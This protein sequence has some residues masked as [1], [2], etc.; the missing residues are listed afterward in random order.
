MRILAIE[1]GSRRA[2]CALLDEPFDQARIVRT[3]GHDNPKE[4]AERLLSMID[5]LLEA[6]GVLRSTLDVIACGLGPGSFTGIRVALATA[7]G[8]AFALGRPLIGVDSLQA[9][10]R[11]VPA[12]ILDATDIVLPTIDAKKG[13]LF[14]AAYS[15]VGEALAP[16]SAVALDDFEAYASTFRGA[17]ITILGE[18]APP[19][20]HLLATWYRSEATDLPMA[21]TIA[22]IARE[23]A[24]RVDFDSLDLLEPTYVRPP[25]AKPMTSVKVLL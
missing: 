5:E 11:A 9:M 17:R 12:S 13:E 4:H 7:K 25:D 1:C 6:A 8:I 16:P 19:R 23:R 2:T 3:L 21:G 18:S 15:R 24:E 20:A 22:Q 14:V 10:V